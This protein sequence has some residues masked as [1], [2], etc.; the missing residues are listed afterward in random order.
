MAVRAYSNRS[1]LAKRFKVADFEGAWLDSID[2]LEHPTLGI[3]LYAH[4]GTHSLEICRG[5]MQSI[6]LAQPKGGAAPI[7]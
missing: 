2:L 3:V 5:R 6:Y 4:D 1:V 7:Q